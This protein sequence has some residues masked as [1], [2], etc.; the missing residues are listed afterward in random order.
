[1]VYDGICQFQNFYKIFNRPKKIWNSQ[2]ASIQQLYSFF[3]KRE[4]SSCR[5]NRFTQFATSWIRYSSWLIATF[6]ESV[7]MEMLHNFKIVFCKL[8]FVCFYGE[9]FG[10]KWFSIMKCFFV[11]HLKRSVQHMLWKIL[12]LKIFARVRNSL[13]CY[14]DSGLVYVQLKFINPHMSWEEDNVRKMTTNQTWKDRVAW[15]LLNFGHSADRSP[16]HP[17]LKTSTQS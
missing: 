17:S 7:H 5:K 9:K 1:M 16:L 8:C 2:V 4:S 6:R 12:F 11:F 3:V 14:W 13:L 10:F 15:K